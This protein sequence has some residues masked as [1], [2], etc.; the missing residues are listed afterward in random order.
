MV[1][2]PLPARD[3]SGWM[4]S[5]GFASFYKLRLMADGNTIEWVHLDEQ[6]LPANTSAESGLDWWLSLMLWLQSLLVDER[7]L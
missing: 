2:S 6:G 1:D 3:L 4:C 5:D 7:D